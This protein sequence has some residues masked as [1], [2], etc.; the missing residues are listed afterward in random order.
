[1]KA[2]IEEVWDCFVNSD[3]INEWGGGNAKMSDKLEEF[4]LWGGDIWGKNILVKK[5]QRLEQ[6]W[7][8][9]KWDEPSI[10]KFVFSKN[11]DSTEVK[12]IHENIP[13]N[14][15][16]SINQGWEEYYL[17]PI[18]ELVERQMPVK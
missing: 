5:F 17:G 13:A 6:E 18:K 3:K 7:F 8:A 11:G 16:K 10:V 1:M 15:F 12:L 9:G 14:E 4:T 2:Q